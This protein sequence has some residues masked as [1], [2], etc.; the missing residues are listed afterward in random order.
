MERIC[1]FHWAQSLEKH[2]KVHIKNCFYGDFVS[3]AYVYK[4]SKT[5]DECD[6]NCRKFQQ[7]IEI[8]K[9]CCPQ[10]EANIYE[11]LVFGKIVSINGH[12][13]FTL[14]VI[15]LC[16]YF[17]SPLLIDFSFSVCKVRI[18][19]LHC[20]CFLFPHFTHALSFSMYVVVVVLVIMFGDMVFG[21]WMQI[22]TLPKIAHMPI[23]NLSENIHITWLWVSRKK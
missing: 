13:S 1:E 2:K 8:S 12:L 22:M 17:W 15:F 9:A 18:G 5:L 4:K 23:Y 21:F 7:W 10:G 20:S 3:L 6:V 11:W 19:S 14:Y 16:V